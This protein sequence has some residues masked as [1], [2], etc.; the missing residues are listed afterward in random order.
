MPFA[1]FFEL[2]NRSPNFLSHRVPQSKG[3]GS[4]VRNGARMLCPFMF[5]MGADED[6]DTATNATYFFSLQH[7]ALLLLFS[8][9]TAGRTHRAITVRS[10]VQ[11]PIGKIRI[12]TTEETGRAM[13]L[14]HINGSNGSSSSSNL[15]RRSSPKMLG[16]FLK[17]SLTRSNLCSPCFLRCCPPR[18]YPLLLNQILSGNSC[19]GMGV[20]GLG[21]GCRGWSGYG[22]AEA[23]VKISAE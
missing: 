13:Q 6:D 14:R 10:A 16:A 5:G 19:C 4:R 11:A 15:K 22:S 17:R 23:A 8:N 12:T 21:C 20:G 3:L 9:S 2:L 18:R 1:C 7:D